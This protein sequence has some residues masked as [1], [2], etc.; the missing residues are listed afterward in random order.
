[1]LLYNVLVS[2]DD[3]FSVNLHSEVNPILTANCLP[4]KIR[5]GRKKK[6]KLLGAAKEGVLVEKYI[7]PRTERTRHVEK[8]IL[9]GTTE[10]V[11]AKMSK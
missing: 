6:K 1:M 11:P 7:H 4:R 5:I 10:I 3:Q 8:E 2:E 9:A